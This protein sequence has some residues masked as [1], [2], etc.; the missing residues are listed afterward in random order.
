M[1]ELLQMDADPVTGLRV[2]GRIETRDFDA[3]VGLLDE[4]F[5]RHEKLQIYAQIESM[6]GISLEAFLKEIQYS[7]RNFRRVDKE[8]VV[9]DKGWLKT[10]VSL[11]DK[12]FPSIEARHFSFEEKAAA[13]AWVRS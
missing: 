11:A 2:R 13:Q 8:A 1:I 9:S 5:Q 4:K 3:V 12:P 10:F 6:G 7:L